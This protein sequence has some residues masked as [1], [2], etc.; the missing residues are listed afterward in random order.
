MHSRQELGGPEVV[1]SILSADFTHLGEQ[2]G[3]L[4]QV[5]CGMLHIDVMDEIGRAHV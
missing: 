5:G 1:P 4:K 3:E 2:I